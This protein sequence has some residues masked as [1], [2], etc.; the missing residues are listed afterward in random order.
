[1]RIRL[2]LLA[3]LLAATPGLHAQYD[4]GGTVRPG[5]V[6]RLRIWQEP[7][8]S[9]DFTVHENGGV[10]LPKLG[11]VQAGGLTDQALRERVV[12]GFGQYLQHN[13]IDVVVLRRIQVLGAVRTPGLYP[14]DGTMSI[15]DVLAV[16]GGTAA[17]ARPD[18]VQLLRGGRR[19][20]VRLNGGERVGDTPIRSGDQI[21]V[22]QRGWADRNTGT[23]V[24]VL[25]ASAG[26]LVAL[27]T[28]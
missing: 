24:S 11:P 3:A 2:F 16:A 17:D 7:D 28:R 12:E 23:V 14:V 19:L 9:G 25:T 22:P 20:D 5:D 1:M 18:R 13:S 6:V 10:V 26:L 15:A 27:L 4:D 21:F 8:L